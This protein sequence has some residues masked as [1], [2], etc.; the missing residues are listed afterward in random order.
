MEIEKLPKIDLHCH[1]D[2]SLALEMIQRHS[3][4]K[5]T[6][7]MLHVNEN[8]KSL[9]EYL[10]KFKLPLECIQDKAGLKDGACTFLK[11]VA[12]ENISYIEVRFAPMFSAHEELSCSQVIESV[13]EGLEE[14]KK[15]SGIRYQV[16]TCAM[17]HHDLKKNLEM[18]HTA[19]EFMGNGVCA[20]DL[21][22]DESAFPT[23]QFQEL[24]KEAHRLEMPFVIH[25]GETGNLDNVKMAYDLGARRIGHGIALIK[26]KDLMR[27]FAKKG[28]GV[29]MCP[30]SNLHTK[31]ISSMAEFPLLEYMKA[32]IKVSINTDNRTVSNTTLTKE[33]KLINDRYQDEDLIYQLLKNAEDT[34]F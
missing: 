30:T 25:S 10:D 32:G 18:L 11:E 2:G 24:F 13:L 31:A 27:Q 21:A 1:L 28:I 14:G 5:I 12:K 17:R 9:T 4:K 8:C 34:A 7:D 23:S 33:L 26:D 22:G 15:E 16:I 3:E 19:R 6:P 29:E 20:I